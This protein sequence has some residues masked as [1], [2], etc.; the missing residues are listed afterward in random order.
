MSKMAPRTIQITTYLTILTKD[1]TEEIHPDC[2]PP[3]PETKNNNQLIFPF[4]P[5]SP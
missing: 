3:E 1:L 5:T 4:F 2:L